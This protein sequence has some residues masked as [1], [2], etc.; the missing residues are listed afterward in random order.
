[1]IIP[2]II[3]KAN[4]KLFV[5]VNCDLLFTLYCRRVVIKLQDNV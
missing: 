5:Q 1:M 4:A 2:V 3:I